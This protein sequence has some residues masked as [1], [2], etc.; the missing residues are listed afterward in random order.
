MDQEKQ[1]VSLLR[2][3]EVLRR[4]GRSRSGMYAD[5]AMGRFPRPV[6]ISEKG[7]AWPS[8]SIDA[9]IADRVAGV[10]IIATAPKAAA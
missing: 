2:L 1:S 7:V 9:W 4:T 3:R 10:P 6:R 5:I 8:V